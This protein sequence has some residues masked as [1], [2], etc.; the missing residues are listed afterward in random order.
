MHWWGRTLEQ[1]P[2]TVWVNAIPPPGLNSCLHQELQSTRHKQ[3]CYSPLPPSTFSAQDLSIFYKH[4]GLEQI[5]NTCIIF[6]CIWQTWFLL[7]ICRLQTHPTLKLPWR[8]TH[9]TGRITFLGTLFLLVSFLLPH[10][11]KPSGA[12]FANSILRNIL[13]YSPERGDVPQ[14]FGVWHRM[15]FT[16]CDPSPVIPQAVT[17]AGRMQPWEESSK[18]RSVSVCVLPRPHSP[19]C[20]SAVLL[21]DHIKRI[22]GFFRMRLP[23]TNIFKGLQKMLPCT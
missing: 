1:C 6:T 18:K 13:K 15:T 12:R 16:H 14:S 19:L 9:R 20:F 17:A 3:H 21:H 5:M 23:A 2:H 11:T 10:D 22:A 4:R 8:R 7:S